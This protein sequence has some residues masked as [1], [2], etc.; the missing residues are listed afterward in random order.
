MTADTTAAD[1][2]WQTLSDALDGYSPECE[3][4]ELFTADSITVPEQA[5][6]ESI[7]ARCRVTDLCDAFA[8]ASKPNTGF[9]GGFRW[10]QQG[11]QPAGPRNRGGR[12]K[13][14]TG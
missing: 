9:W 2:A 10:T 3:G 8:V 1:D 4:W 5:L 6:A 13:Q 11:K 7:C 12:P 14:A